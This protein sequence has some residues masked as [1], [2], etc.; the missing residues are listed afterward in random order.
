MI[1]KRNEEIFE[2]EAASRMTANDRTVLVSG[3]AL[4]TEETLRSPA[5]DRVFIA[6]RFPIRD[7]DGYVTGLAAICTDVT[8]RRR[9]ES[10]LR[11]S[12]E[13]YRNV[14]E[15]AIEGLAIHQGG[16]IRFAN[17]AA[18]RIAGCAI[19]GAGWPGNL[20]DCRFGSRQNC[21]SVAPPC[22]RGESLPMHDGWPASGRTARGSG[23]RVQSPG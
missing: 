9:A 6:S 17:Q 13:H 15:G 18:A 21:A 8:E 10:A 14:V 5:G 11:Q 22:L 4:E 2:P 7:V 12:E 1:G 20:V 23:S 16:I 3:K 19:R